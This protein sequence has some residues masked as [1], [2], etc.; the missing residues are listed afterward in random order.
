MFH[1]EMKSQIRSLVLN[2]MRLSV[3]V[4]PSLTAISNTVPTTEG[5][6]L[7]LLLLLPL[8]P[9]PLPLRPLPAPAPPPTTAAEASG[10]L[11][12]TMASTRRAVSER[13]RGLPGQAG[14][15]A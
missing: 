11:D 2:E 10:A 6:E 5:G 9:L 14:T 1:F 4:V 15:S 13:M 12:R 8:F 7:T 3:L